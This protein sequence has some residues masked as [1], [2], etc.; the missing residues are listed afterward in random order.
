[1]NAEAEALMEAPL[2]TFMAVKDELLA[3]LQRRS[4]GNAR[5]AGTYQA[6]AGVIR[7][8]GLQLGC[9]SGFVLTSPLL[10]V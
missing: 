4:A 8:R 5:G 7:E 6:D 2:G 10:S 1:G 3:E 9:N